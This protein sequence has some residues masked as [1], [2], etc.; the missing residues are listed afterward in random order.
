[1]RFKWW[2]GVLKPRNPKNATVIDRR[3]ALRA[4]RSLKLP[5][6][7]KLSSLQKISM[8]AISLS[9]M[10]S[11]HGEWKTASLTRSRA[12]SISLKL[13]TRR[14]FWRKIDNRQD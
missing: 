6:R 10:D 5:V 12:A 11:G 14:Q 4:P 7:C 8:P 9:E 13:I 2:S 1:L 3:S